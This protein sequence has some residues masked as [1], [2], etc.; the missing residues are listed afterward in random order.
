MTKIKKFSISE[1]KR[2]FKGAWDP[3]DIAEFSGLVLRVARF[4]GK[5]LED[6]HTHVYDEFFLVLEG[7]IEI[8]TTPGWC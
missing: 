6:K 7:N 8:D 2:L 1:V 5:Y 3:K 4:E